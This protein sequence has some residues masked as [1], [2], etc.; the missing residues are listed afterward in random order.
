MTE[1]FD[2]LKHPEIQQTE[3][4]WCKINEKGELEIFNWE[5]VERLAKEYDQTAENVQRNNGQII[6][7]LA[8]LIREQ[9]ARACSEALL[10]YADQSA[11]SRLIVLKEFSQEDDE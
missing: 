6:A 4:V 1:E 3:E 8:V 7:K 10:K 5:F 11:T 2:Y 9:T